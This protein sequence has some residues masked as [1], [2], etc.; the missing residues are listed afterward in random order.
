MGGR[1]GIVTI[2]IAKR[3]QMAGETFI[4]GLFAGIKA[5]VFQKLQITL[6]FGGGIQRGHESHI[7]AQCLFQR[8]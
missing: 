3:G 6:R 7:A 2:D 4:I 8:G 5:D 1:E